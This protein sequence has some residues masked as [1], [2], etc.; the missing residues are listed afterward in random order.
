[1][2]LEEFGLD[3]LQIENAIHNK[4]EVS[5]FFDHIHYLQANRMGPTVLQEKMII[6]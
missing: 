3:Y 1:L 2:D 5:N 4:V 6:K